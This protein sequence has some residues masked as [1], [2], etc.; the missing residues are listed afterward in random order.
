MYQNACLAAKWCIS[1]CAK[2]NYRVYVCA[3]VRASMHACMC[4]SVCLS[5]CEIFH[6]P[7]LENTTSRCT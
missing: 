2:S 5:L 3:C 6:L 4:A 1:P 7:S